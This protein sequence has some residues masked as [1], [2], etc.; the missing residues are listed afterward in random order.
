MEAMAAEQ[1]ESQLPSSPWLERANQTLK[2]MSNITLPL[3][4]MSSFELYA[5]A[6]I[7]GIACIEPNAQYIECKV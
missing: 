5:V 3:H 2:E 4:P 6:S 1:G 7:L